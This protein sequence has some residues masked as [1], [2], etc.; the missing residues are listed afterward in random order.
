MFRQNKPGPL[1]RI[2]REKKFG[3]YFYFSSNA[4]NQDPE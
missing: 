4:V 2:A 3:K 1:P